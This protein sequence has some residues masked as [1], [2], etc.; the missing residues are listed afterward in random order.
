[1]SQKLQ[2]QMEKQRAQ[3]GMTSI[4]SRVSEFYAFVLFMNL[5]GRN[6]FFC[7]I[8]SYSRSGNCK[9]D[10]LGAAE[11][12]HKLNLLL[13]F[14]QLCESCWSSNQYYSKTRMIVIFFKFHC[15][16]LKCA[17]SLIKRVVHSVLTCQKVINLD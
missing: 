17:R 14:S 7:G 11:G 5:G 8:Y 12:A 2:R 1:M 16:S 4:K 6:G 10:G 15:C 3:G 9:S 13:F